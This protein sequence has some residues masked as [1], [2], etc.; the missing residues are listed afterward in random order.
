M[1]RC[2]RTKLSKKNL[3]GNA[4]FVHLSRFSE[5]L[6]LPKIL[7]EHLTIERGASA[8]Y[9]VSDIVMMLKREGVIF[10]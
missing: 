2:F 5:K 7:A 9:Q 1:M 4:G 8:D 6:D 10:Q 3:T